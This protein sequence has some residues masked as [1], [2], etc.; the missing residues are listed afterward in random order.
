VLFD[1]HL[2]IFDPAFP[3]PGNQGFVPEHFTVA[4]YRA[5]TA[6]LEVTGGAVVA[7]STQGTD[8]APL[9]A[10]AAAL[11]PRFVVV[12]E[13][14]AG[15]DEADLA[16]L[17]AAGVRGVRFNLVRSGAFSLAAML[18]HALKAADAGLHAELYADAATLA[19][20]VDALAALPCGLALDHLGMTEAGLPVT[21]SLAAAGVKVKA[22]GF[23]RVSLDVPR[24]LETI[25]N[26]SPRSLMAAT[27]LP[28]TRAPRPFADD[29]LGLIARVLGPELTQAAL[30]DTAAA[31]YRAPPLSP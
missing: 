27:D 11:G 12:A 6:S 18:A 14:H 21:V 31:F 9:L 7:A 25:A 29:D 10:A 30:H 1:A 5:R 2:H 16:A 26:A 23:G 8:P 24:A 19:D 22:T 13:A 3:L 15:Q 17:A 20:H 28:S 4:D